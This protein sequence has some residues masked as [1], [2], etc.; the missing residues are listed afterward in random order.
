ME[1]PRQ[2]IPK[3]DNQLNIEQYRALKAQ[4]AQEAAQ[5]TEQPPAGAGE[6]PQTT[7]Q[8][9]PQSEEPTSTEEPKSEEEPKEDQKPSE[10]VN[11]EGIGEVNFEELKN[12]Y[13]RQSDYTK[14]TQDVSRRSKELEEAE[15]LYNHL[16]QNPQ[17]A[18]QLLQT[19]QVP[20]QFDPQQNKVV[21]LEEKVYDMMLQQEIETLQKKYDDFEVKEVLET[22]QEKK[23]TDLED[24]YLLAKSRKGKGEDK[25]DKEA[26]KQEL[27][28]ELKKEQSASQDADATKSAIT[29]SDAAPVVE[30][31]SPKLSDTE[32]NVARNMRMSDEEYVKWRDAGRKKK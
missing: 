15:K 9:P 19:K 5:A 16:K 3:E 6:H 11:I 2:G 32:Q 1:Q 21:E 17:M 4:E 14:K 31:N 18:Q 29:S 10:T 13:L 25:V 27:L 24:A 7:P 23:I 20:Q 28:Q 8:N 30:D 22:A 12:G 26:I